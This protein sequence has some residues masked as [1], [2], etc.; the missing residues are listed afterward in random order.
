MANGVRL[1]LHGG[2]LDG[3]PLDGAECSVPD[4]VELIVFC[5]DVGKPAFCYQHQACPGEADRWLPILGMDLYFVSG[6]EYTTS[7]GSVTCPLQ[8]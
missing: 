4:Y 1:W 7:A 3:G 6:G 2:P 5:R 8:P